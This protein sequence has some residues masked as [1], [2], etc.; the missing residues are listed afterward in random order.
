MG[1]VDFR[2]LA[3]V[4]PIAI[5]LADE[6]GQILFVNEAAERLFQ[7]SREEL[8]GQVVEVLVPPRFRAA[9]P[10]HRHTYFA[11]PSI[12]DER[13]HRD[14]CGVRKDGSE[15]SLEIRLAVLE[16]VAGRVAIA[17]VVDITERKRIED[18]LRAER[19]FRQSTLDALSSSVAIVDREGRIIA[20]NASWRAFAVNNHFR[21]E[22]SALDSNYLEVCDT[23]S[24][25]FSS[26]AAQVA[27][28]IRAVMACELDEF[29]LEYPCH[30]PTEQRW[31][32]VRV[33]RFQGGGPVRV[34]IAHEDIT[35]RVCAE[36]AV[37]D[38]VMRFEA[39]IRNAADAICVVDA[40]NTIQYASPAMERLV[41]IKPADLVGTSATRYV[42]AD[43]YPALYGGFASTA[44]H[45]QYQAE[46]RLRHLNGSWTAVEIAGTALVDDPNTRGT[47]LNVRDITDR[48]RLE[49]LRADFMA[50]VAHDLRNPLAVIHGA[51]TILLEDED[52][53]V[54]GREIAGAA[55][56]SVDSAL[57]LLSNFLQASQLES[58]ELTLTRQPVSV[59]DLLREVS[60]ALVGERAS[61]QSTLDLNLAAELPVIDADPMA[62]ERV[63]SNLL[64]NAL[65]FTPSSGQITI[66]SELD[67]S[68]VIVSVTDTGPGIA[69]EE[70]P[71]L[72]D[73]YRQTG[74]GLSKGGSGLGLF[75][76]RSLVE[77]HGGAVHLTSTLGAGSCF[78]VRLP[79]KIA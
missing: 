34:V 16:S 14:L 33:T 25:E 63:F 42:H 9:H 24:G 45:E 49:Q 17:S 15:V 58:G 79:S 59:N 43:D 40:D 7:Y 60:R 2:A 70:I 29:H 74:E 76:V 54:E 75:I 56:R 50:M 20:V 41:G 37:H 21:G 46:A 18:E 27:A 38:S 4:A 64:N 6:H 8:I 61:H 72:F 66:R 12:G 67:A 1:G 31:F 69:P 5:L 48:K 19:E 22:A 62:L 13:T 51:T 47:I 26:E 71:S 32:I 78:Q 68:W 73:R 23:A 53:S 35:E 30:S 10:Q 55:K 77:A 28:G 39:L 36:R 65:K 44:S 11:A 3:A 57:A 52:L